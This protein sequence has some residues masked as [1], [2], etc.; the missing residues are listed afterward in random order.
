MAP[1]RATSC[2][3]RCFRA[4]RRRGL[5]RHTPRLRRDM[6]CVDGGVRT[7]GRRGTETAARA[8]ATRR[9]AET[10]APTTRVHMATGAPQFSMTSLAH[11]QEARHLGLR[12]EDPTRRR[13]REDGITA[14]VLA[15]APAVDLS[16]SASSRHQISG[17]IGDGR[18]LVVLGRRDDGRDLLLDHWRRRRRHRSSGRGARARRR[19]S[20]SWGGGGP[21]TMSVTTTKPLARS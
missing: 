6:P 10:G 7:V 2:G 16:R 20:L 3:R 13:V 5:P 18:A 21:S 1:W 14:R 11:V 9:R 15:H 8:R 4:S 12:P 19:S 17:E